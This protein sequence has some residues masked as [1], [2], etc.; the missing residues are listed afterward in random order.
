MAFSYDSPSVPVLSSS[1]NSS[2]LSMD[3]YTQSN[4]AN[5]SIWSLCFL[6][7]TCL[8]Y[9]GIVFFSCVDEPTHGLVGPLSPRVKPLTLYFSIIIPLAIVLV[10]YLMSIVNIILGDVTPTI[11]DNDQDLSLTYLLNSVML[12]FS[13][14]NNSLLSLLQSSGSILISKVIFFL[15]ISVALLISV[16]SIADVFSSILVIDFVPDIRLTIF[17]AL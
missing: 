2:L 15:I 11:L 4:F 7:K 3:A 16:V 9:T 14:L 12:R 10:V 6:V 5:K 8:L 1:M 17:S 13:K